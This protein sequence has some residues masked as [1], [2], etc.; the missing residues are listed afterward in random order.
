MNT[1]TGQDYNARWTVQQRPDVVIQQISSAAATS[2]GYTFQMT[3]PTS[4][5][6]TRKYW[7]MWLIIAVIIGTFFFLIGLLGLL[8]KETETLSVTAGEEGDATTVNLSGKGSSELIGR[9]NAF[10]ASLPGAQQTVMAMPTA[11]PMA[12]AYP[13]APP[14]V[15]APSPVTPVAQPQAAPAP[16]E[17]SA[18]PPPPP[19]DDAHPTSAGWYRDQS[20]RHEYRYWNG[21][22]WTDDVSD[23]GQQSKDPIA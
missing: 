9:L 2:D 10:L 19:P 4:V 14:S 18:P 15:A 3:G 16:A 6:L 17:S 11:F 23:H 20:G 5:V 12:T 13:A 7:P 8:Y 1:S 22:A 21:S